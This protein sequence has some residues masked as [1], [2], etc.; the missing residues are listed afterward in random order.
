AA[1]RDRPGVVGRLPETRGRPGPR[2]A[3]RQAGCPHQGDARGGKAVSAH[4][5]RRSGSRRLAR[6]AALV[7]VAAGLI[8]GCGGV[9]DAHPLGNFTVN[10]YSG[11]VVRPDSIS[12]DFVVDMAEIPAY[13]TRQD[14]GIGDGP[15]DGAPAVQFR[16][17]E[18]DQIAGRIS[19]Q[20]SG[21]PL[22][23]QV[24]STSLSF[25]PGQAGLSTLR[26]TCSLLSGPTERPAHVTYRSDNFTDRV[27][28][29]EITAAG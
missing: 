7:A 26:L 24:V 14:T 28:W 10:T 5:F 9:G 22:A 6:L 18:C 27:G 15:A 29:R 12:V 17:R 16:S 21:Q 3:L 4:A 8:G 20:A 19:L 13:Q 25:P 23:L 2:R 1:R 11:L